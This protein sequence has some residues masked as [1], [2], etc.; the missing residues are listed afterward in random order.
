M[1]PGMTHPLTEM[2]TRNTAWEV[3]VVDKPATFMCR[4]SRNSGSLGL[5]EPKE[6][7]QACNWITFFTVV[8]C[9]R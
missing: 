2:S 6:P 7:A 4:L 1:S 9:L 3:R 8:V 5:Q